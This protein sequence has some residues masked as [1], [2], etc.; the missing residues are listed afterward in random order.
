VA[1]AL[2]REGIRRH[3]AGLAAVALVLV[4]GVGAG[5]TSL[6]VADRTQ[7][8]YPNYLRRAA[9]GE[10]VVNPSF[11][12]DRTESI[13]RSV[14]GVERVRSDSLLTVAVN[15]N[16]GAVTKRT[17][18]DELQDQEF[19]QVRVSHD[20]RYVGQDRPTVTSG[21]MIRSGHEAF[22]SREA[23]RALGVDVGDMLPLEVYAESFTDPGSYSRVGSDRVRVVGVGVFADEV[24][25]DEL[26]PRQKMLVTSEAGRRFDCERHQ[27][28]ADDPRSYE[29]IVAT[30]SPRC[31]QSYRYFSMQVR[32]GDGG[33]ARVADALGARFR[34]ENRHL[35]Q[36][37]RD[38][39]VGYEVIPSFRSDDA[40]HV[41]ES[42]SPVVTALRAFGIVATVATIAVASL[43]ISVLLRRRSRD[44]R[45]WR[46]LGVSPAGRA[47]GLAL[48][49]VGAVI[50]GLAGAAVVAWLAS[51]MGPV[52]SV[53]AVVPHP[54]RHLSIALALPVVATSLLLG[55]GVAF[56]ALRVARTPTAA[57]SRPSAPRRVFRSGVRSPALALGAR[58]AT[59]GPGAGALLAGVVVATTA[60][61]A[62]LVFSASVVRF[63]DSPRR[64]GWPFDVAAIVNAG[65][66]PTDLAKVAHTLDRPD[67]ERWGVAALGGGIVVNGKTLPSIAARR[68]FDALT[69]A[70]TISGRAPE[71][72]NEI[73]LGSI[74]ARHLGLHVGDKAKVSTRFGSRQARVSGLVVL[75]AVGPLESDRTSLGTGV[76][77][78]NRFFDAMVGSPEM[79]DSFGGFVAIELARGVDPAAFLAHIHRGLVGWNPAFA[80]PAFA[81]PVRPATVVEVAGSRRV[82][83]LLALVLALTMAV[84]VVAGIASGTRARRLELALLRAF[85]GAPRLVRSTVRWHGLVVVAIA[86]L[87]GLPLGVALGRVG[88][89]AFARDIGA[90]PQPVV[91]LTL[92]TIVVAVAIGLAVVAAALP[93]RHAATRSARSDVLWRDDR[94][95]PTREM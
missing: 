67:V 94:Q 82:P 47:L 6:E 89:T 44:A 76:L 90:A 63:V 59:A 11:V 46:A 26:F 77:L 54:S 18:G 8:A 29:E 15:L 24:Q 61:M 4:T 73:A 80:T 3:F 88:F 64:F 95:P 57:D 23:A 14:R 20:G 85:G 48:P 36:A 10:L 27:P 87:V 34:E 28:D 69:P 62:T 65:Y 38:H 39:G 51:V 71:R 22:L 68:G 75:P 50:A 91:P 58:A 31:S 79:A 30:M 33:A 13:I 83:L 92:L 70:L 32:G 42:L 53:R 72:D 45:V 35:P 16:G 41:R 56:A 2:T 60:V 37:I 7:H 78:S 66:G 5:W 49:P 43:L 17:A 84:S 81:A 19:L 40:A 86:L 55:I 52:A 9:V 12:T 1:G 21:R 74:T 93:A 25:P